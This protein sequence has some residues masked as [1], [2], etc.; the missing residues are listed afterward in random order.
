MPAISEF[1]YP[2]EEL[3]LFA[4]ARRWKAYWASR[5]RD[6]LGENVLEVGA[7][8]GANTRLLCN[9]RHLR[10]VCLEPDAILSERMR[11]FL[12]RCTCWR[13]CEVITGTLSDFEKDELFDTILFIDVLEHIEDDAGE[14]ARASL[15]LKPEGIL[16][17]LSPAHQC[18]I[19]DFDH[20]VGHHRRYT[21][22]MLTDIAPLHLKLIQQEYLDCVGLLASLANRLLLRR[23]YPTRAQIGFWDSTMVRCSRILDPLFLHRFGKSILTVWRRDT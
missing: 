13:F 1:V 23:H 8:I 11:V 4:E 18:L 7:G 6:H 12:K 22:K 21:K 15:H 20:A 2:G 9:R 16:I 14:L 3:Q 10:W 5:I 17:V 19:S